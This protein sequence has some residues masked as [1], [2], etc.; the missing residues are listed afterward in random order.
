MK[1]LAFNG[2]PRRGRNSQT[3]LAKAIRSVDVS[4]PLPQ[5]MRP[6]QYGGCVSWEYYNLDRNRRLTS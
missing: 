3:L 5:R 2:S 4:A 1:V 6:C